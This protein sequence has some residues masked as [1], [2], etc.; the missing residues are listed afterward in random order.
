MQDPKTPFARIM[1]LGMML[2]CALMLVPAIWFLLA[3]GTL[4]GLAANWP[5]FLPLV[6]CAGAHLLMHGAT[7]RACHG[8]GHDHGGPAGADTHDS[9]TPAPQGKDTP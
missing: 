2:C 1:K 6:L 8:H 4:A 3:G 7:G 5:L 9:P